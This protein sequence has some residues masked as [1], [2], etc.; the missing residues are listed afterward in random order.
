MRSVFRSCALVLAVL[1]SALVPTESNAMT[2]NVEQLAPAQVSACDQVPQLA[3][4]VELNVAEFTAKALALDSFVASE[5]ATTAH[6]N[7]TVAGEFAIERT[8]SITELRG[9]T[10]R[11][12]NSMRARVRDS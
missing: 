5:V 2:P 8:D 3:P 10:W 9:P 6:A 4:S 11:P 12:H 7:T 1:A